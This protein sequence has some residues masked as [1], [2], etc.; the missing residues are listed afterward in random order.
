MIRRPKKRA[1]AAA[2]APASK[3]KSAKAALRAPRRLRASPRKTPKKK[4]AAQLARELDDAHAHQS[5][6]AD[7][8]KLISR[9]ACDLPRVLETLLHSAARL[10][11]ARHGGIFRGS[12]GG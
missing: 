1:S 8:L 4:S 3:R 5:A 9:S 6:T 12:A 2:R 11:G 7:V 10:C